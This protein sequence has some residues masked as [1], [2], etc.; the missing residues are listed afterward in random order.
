MSKRPTLK[1]LA[2]IT[3][4]S[5]ATVSRALNDHPRISKES[6]SKIANAAKKLGYQPNTLARG[7]RE[8]RSYMIGLI[9]GDIENHFHLAITKTILEEAKIEGYHVIIRSTLGRSEGVSEAIDDMVRASVDG[10]ILTATKLEEN[11]LTEL[12]ED[13]FPVVQVMRRLRSAIGIQIIPDGNYGVQMLV[14]H[15]LRIGHKRIAMIGG[16]ENL[17]TS[18]ARYDGYYQALVANDI[19][20]DQRLILKGDSYNYDTGYINCKKL[21]RQKRIPDAIVCGDDQIAF[22]A[23]QV[24]DEAGLQIPEDMA[25]VGFDNCKMAAHPRIQLTS[26]HYDIN[27]LSRLAV[28]NLIALIDGKISGHNLIKIVPQLI[29][30]KT[31]GYQS[32]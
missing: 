12:I 9:I 19:S 6:K 7:F 13:N 21:L 20:I 1:D 25:V 27:Q 4:F 10:I 22:G 15:L 11:S 17:S 32:S 23:M 29:A 2:E 18:Q 24:I 31:C 8:R 3:G 30:R 14:N 26:I 28:T 5:A 16:P